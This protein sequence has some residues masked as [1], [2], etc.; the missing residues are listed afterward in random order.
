MLYT[1]IKQ[2]IILLDS[3]FWKFN[4]WSHCEQQVK[5]KWKNDIT[6]RQMKC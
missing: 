3:L 2:K 6:A 5:I 4:I 1:L